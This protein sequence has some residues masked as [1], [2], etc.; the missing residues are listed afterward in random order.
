MRLI[1]L[2]GRQGAGKDTACRLLQINLCNSREILTR[3][4]KYAFAEALKDCASEAFGI[5][6]KYFYRDEIL[7]SEI[8]K[9][10]NVS[11]R[12][13]AQ[14]LGTE[15]FREHIKDLC[16]EVGDRFWIIRLEKDIKESEESYGSED[17]INVITDVRFQNEVDWIIENEGIIIKINREGLPGNP[18]L[19]NH[20]SDAGFIPP[21]ERYHEVE[22]NGTPQHLLNELM[23]IIPFYFLMK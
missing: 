7:K 1:G 17:V 6:K 9:P 22:N 18:G 16:P 4:H 20:K 3:F 2:A 15:M 5:P 19:P 23:K 11:A 14:F 10:W 8:H 12:Q 21:K 13:I